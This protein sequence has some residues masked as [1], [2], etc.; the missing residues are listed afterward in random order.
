MICQNYYFQKKK[1]NIFFS[2]YDVNSYS[3]SV[4]TLYNNIWL[5]NSFFKLLGTINWHSIKKKK[6]P[7]MKNIKIVLSNY[8]NKTRVINDLKKN[9]IISPKNKN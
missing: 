2:Y 4:I 5:I 7:T 3:L 8:K 1:Y 6:K 9:N